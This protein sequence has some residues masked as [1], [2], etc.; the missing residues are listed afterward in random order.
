VNATARPLGIDS[1]LT[2]ERFEN[3]DIDPEHFDHEAHVYIAWLYVQNYELA[4][5]IAKFD[6]GLKRLVAKLGADGK[7][8]ATLTWFFLLLIADR[9]EDDQSWRDFRQC[10]TDLIANSKD[11]L[12]RYYSHGYLFSKRAR[13]RFVFPDKLAVIK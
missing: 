11:L 4:E 10:N 12:S 2:I 7:Y 3:A 6:S 13:E 8:H 1:E 5:A 9:A